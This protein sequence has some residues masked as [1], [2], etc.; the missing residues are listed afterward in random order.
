MS[1]EVELVPLPPVPAHAS[2][3]LDTAAIAR[4]TAYGEALATDGVV[5]GLIGPRE[6][7]I[8]WDRHLLNCAAMAE[9]LKPNL[10]VADIGTGAGLPGMVLA[11][12]RPDLSVVLVDTL[13]RRCEFLQEM[14]AQFDLGDRVEVIWGRAETIAPLEADI[15]TSRA[16]A[17][18]KKLAPWCFPHVR[19]GG[20]LLAMKGQKAAEELVAAHKVLHRWSAA[21]DAKI[22]TCGAGWIN[23]TVTLVS[24]TRR[25]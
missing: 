11:L 14:V 21:K 19:I 12:V 18:L 23:P 13:Q 9:A 2:K 8:L 17:A 20:R 15:V 5:R 7:P 3:R 22:I 16:V 1:E 24:A 25:K 4:L 10:K 6:V